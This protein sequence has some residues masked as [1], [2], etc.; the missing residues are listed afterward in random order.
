MPGPLDMWSDGEWSPGRLGGGERQECV[1]PRE[2]GQEC[3]AEGKGVLTH[4]SGCAMLGA[5]AA[6][7]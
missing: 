2:A 7:G 4:V 1:E 6:T 3:R 5:L